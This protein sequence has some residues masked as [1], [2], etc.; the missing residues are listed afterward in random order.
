MALL[1]TSAPALSE[2]LVRA[3]QARINDFIDE[4]VEKL[5][6]ECPGVPPP[7]IRSILTN[8]SGGCECRSYLNIKEAGA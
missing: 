4:H 5:R 7:V 2:E 8:R 3:H 6:L 1:K